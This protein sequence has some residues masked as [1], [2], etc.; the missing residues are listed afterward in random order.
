MKRPFKEDAKINCK[1]FPW[2]EYKE[3]SKDMLFDMLKKWNEEQTTP[4]EANEELCTV[5][6]RLIESLA[7]WKRICNYS[8]PWI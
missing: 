8:K 5:I 6:H 3:Q 2:K 4:E 7:S 1:T